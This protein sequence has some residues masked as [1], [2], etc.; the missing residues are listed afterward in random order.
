MSRE[1]T[2]A[3]LT[4]DAGV[5]VGLAKVGDIAVTIDACRLSRI[6]NWPG[7]VRGKRTRPIRPQPAVIARYKDPAEAEKECD[8]D[9][10]Q[11]RQPKQVFVR[12]EGRHECSSDGRTLGNYGAAPS[13]LGFERYGAMA[14]AICEFFSS[15]V[16]NR[17]GYFFF[18]LPI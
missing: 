18:K 9:G 12:A 17:A 10:K 16:E 13:P 2:V 15:L 14:T 7:L 6:D 4:T 1:W 11:G 3:T 8:P 5:R